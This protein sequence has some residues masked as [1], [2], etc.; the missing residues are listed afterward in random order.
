VDLIGW[1][2]SITDPNLEILNPFLNF[3]VQVSQGRSARRCLRLKPEGPYL[4]LGFKYH[5]LT[6]KLRLSPTPFDGKLEET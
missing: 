4:N 6:E 1:P 5:E 2:A 3:K